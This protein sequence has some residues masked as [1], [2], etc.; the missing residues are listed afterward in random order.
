[1]NLHQPAFASWI[2]SPGE[3]TKAQ[4]SP[5]KTFRAGVVFHQDSC[6]WRTLGNPLAFLPCISRTMQ[7]QQEHE[8]LHRTGSFSLSSPDFKS[9]RV[10]STTGRTDRQ[11]IPPTTV[12][13]GMRL[14]CCPLSR[15]L[16]ACFWFTT[17]SCSHLHALSCLV[18][19]VSCSRGGVLSWTSIN[20]FLLPLVRYTLFC[21]DY[22]KTT[23]F[24]SNKVSKHWQIL[25]SISCVWMGSDLTPQVMLTGY[26]EQHKTS[27]KEAKGK[28]LQAE[29]DWSQVSY[30]FLLVMAYHNWYLVI[31]QEKKT[32]FD[33]GLVSIMKLLS[34]CVC[35]NL[36][37]YKIFLAI[38]VPCVSTS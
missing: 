5:I 4:V 6:S 37:I 34:W 24:F 32:I 33:S 27:T 17:T 30:L 9:H 3:N 25:V 14:H 8:N 28:A 35:L 15:L 12:A 29:Y 23:S 36:C 18:A 13:A 10:T 1:M 31:S 20:V 11:E 21:K 26:L 38:Y 22:C 7:E 16:P 19:L 2:L